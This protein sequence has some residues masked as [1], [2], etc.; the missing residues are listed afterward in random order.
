[1]SISVKNNA[2]NLLLQLLQTSTQGSQG[3]GKL[4]LENAGKMLQMLGQ[5][6]TALQTLQDSIQGKSDSFGGG[7]KPGGT[8]G[9][10]G[11]EGTNPLL[12]Q[13]QQLLQTLEAL[14]NPQAGGPQQG[15]GG[16]P[17]SQQGGVAL[18]FAAQ[19]QVLNNAKQEQAALLSK[20]S[21][22]VKSGKITPQEL[23]PL[24]Q[25]VKKLAEATRA[26]SADG[27]V[28]AE[29]A[30]NLQKL[31]MENIT[32]TK[33]AF[34]NGDKASFASINPASQHQAQQLSDIAKGLEDGSISNLELTDLAEEQGALAEAQGNIS[35]TEDASKLLQAQQLTDLTIQLA[36]LTNT[37]A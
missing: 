4:S 37:K 34:E 23:G 14:Q 17:G 11:A 7:N 2:N 13:F 26:A 5:M 15:P 20:I 30:A 25:G 19:A 29:E 27:N 9:S 3:Q 16:A 33:S 21:E 31:S 18:P 22:G 10:G 24:M 8:N 6:M 1:M 36:R 32:N 28:T 12:Q 35:S